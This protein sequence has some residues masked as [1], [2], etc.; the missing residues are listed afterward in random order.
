MDQ[1]EKIY[2]I[3]IKNGQEHRA[4]LTPEDVNLSTEFFF[5]AYQEAKYQLREIVLAS[6]RISKREKRSYPPKRRLSNCTNIQTM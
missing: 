4:A 3:H 5:N 1:K 2:E 6:A